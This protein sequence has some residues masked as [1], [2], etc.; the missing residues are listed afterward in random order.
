MAG[1]DLFAAPVAQGQSQGVDLFADRPD[2]AAPPAA[3]APG[4][5]Q[6]PPEEPPELSWGEVGAQAIQ[7]VP[8]SG[9]QYFQNMWQAVSSPIETGGTLYDIAD[10]AVRLMVPGGDSPNEAKAKAVGDFFSERYGTTSGFKNA[11]ATDPVGVMGDFATVLTG[12][13]FAAARAPGLAGKVANVARQA[14]NAIE[15]VNLAVKGVQ[16][17]GKIP[18]VVPAIKKAGEVAGTGAGAIAGSLTGVGTEATRIAAQAGYKG[19][20]AGKAWRAA[21]KGEIPWQGLVD[22]ATAA[23]RKMHDAKGAAYRTSREAWGESTTPIAFQPINDAFNK[24]VGRG[25]FEGVDIN[26]SVTGY[27]EELAK[28]V[29]E[30]GGMD[31]SKFHTPLGLDAL[32]QRIGDVLNKVPFENKNARG[33]VGEVYHAVKAEIVKKAPEYAKAMREYENASELI[34]NIEGSFKLNKKNANLDSSVRALTSTLR[35]NVNTNYGARVNQAKMLEEA[36]APNLMEKLAGASSSS[37]MPRGIQGAGSAAAGLTMGANIVSGATNPLSLL[38]LGATSP[39][40]VGEA[41]HSGGRVAGGVRD[42]AGVAKQAANTPLAQKLLEYGA[43]G[44]GPGARLG[45]AQAGRLENE[46]RGIR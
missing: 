19:G 25:K 40:L 23:V 32:K 27:V 3:V 34:R 21:I 14:G 20:E 33:V 6:G 37:F 12:G 35:N 45:A 39:R 9:K 11:V 26:P 30:W 42:A 46:L 18:G 28:V 1:I 8:D 22:D 38:L 15:P 10:G 31:P 43:P 4:P 44:Y 17:L 36:G 2:L 13:G 7:N 16:G 41:A 29:E 5:M 24:I